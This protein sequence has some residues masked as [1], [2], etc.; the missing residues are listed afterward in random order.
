MDKSAE[1]DSLDESDD[2]IS[3]KEWM[4]ILEKEARDEE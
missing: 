3:E 2:E 4:Q 1:T